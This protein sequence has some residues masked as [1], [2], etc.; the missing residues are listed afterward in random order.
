MTEEANGPEGAAASADNRAD[1]TVI[2]DQGSNGDSAGPKLAGP[3]N[4]DNRA[5]VEA[6]KWAG[7]DGSID[8]NKVVE[9]YRNLETH[10]SKSLKVPGEDATAEDWNKFYSNLGRPEKAD[11]YELALDRENLPE[12]FP[13]DEQSAVE[14]RNWAHEAG[15]TP[16]QAQALHDKF[17]GHQAGNFTAMVEQR[18]KSEGD[19]H[20]SIVDEW[21]GTESEGYKRNVELASRAIHQLGLKD[22][23]KEGGLLSADGAILNAKAAFAMS[24]VGKELYAEDSMAMSSSGLA[25]NPFADG[26]NF[27]RSKQGELIRS[28]PKRAKAYMQAAGKNPAEYGLS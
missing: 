21:G 12:E 18:K 27:N 9:G 25:A 2:P 5:T 17:V 14:F 7:E 22:A 4:E 6:K 20:R 23:F 3:L 24:K 8:L 1:A 10:A 13:Y 15:L 28:Y 26:P 19:A 11:G 16:K